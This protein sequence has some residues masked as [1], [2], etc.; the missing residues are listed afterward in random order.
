M[1]TLGGGEGKLALDSLLVRY[2]D[3]SQLRLAKLPCNTKE[4]IDEVISLIE[5]CTPR[6]TFSS[7]EFFAEQPLMEEQK[8]EITKKISEALFKNPNLHPNFID[9][10]MSYAT[11]RAAL[12]L[13][14]SRLDAS[15]G[16]EFPPLGSTD[17][18]TDSIPLEGVIARLSISSDKSAASTDSREGA[19]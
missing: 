16:E 4:D 15:S 12:R 17:S 14:P 11:R 5:K 13:N 8:K 10:Q 19:N 7:L 2:T 3:I 1:G 18:T 9:F 6:L